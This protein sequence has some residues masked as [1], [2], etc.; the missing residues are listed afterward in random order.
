[1][2]SK[3][4]NRTLSVNGVSSVRSRGHRGSDVK[5]KFIFITGGVM[6][7]LGK[8]IITS[9]T[10][11]L[12]QLAGMKVSCV[13][14]DPYVN[15]DAG[16]MNPIAHGEVFVTDDGGEC[17]MD[18][19]NYERFLGLSLTKEHSL[20]TGRVYSGVIHA[21]REGKYLGQCVQIIPHVTDA[22][23]SQLRK[24][25]EDEELDI[26]VVECGGTVGDIESLP[27][28][29]ALRQM[30]LEDGKSNTLFIHVTLAPVLDVV[31]EQ[32]TKPTQHSVQELRRIGIQ[33]DM[34]AI[35]CR[36]P[37]TAEA[38][39]KIS[40]FGS[41]DQDSVISC[42][43]APSIYKVPEV[44]AGQGMLKVISKKLM[45]PNLYPKWGDWKSI[46]KS[47]YKSKG[48]VRI[49]VVGKYASLPDSYVS[50]YHALSHAAANTGK[51]IEIEWIESEKF[52]FDQSDLT[53]CDSSV[54]DRTYAEKIVAGS[55][56]VAYLERFHGILIP[57]GF[58]KRG[59]EGII[60][61]AN[62]ARL[63]NIPYLGICFGFQLAIVAFAR[64]ACG[65]ESAN[66]TELDPT[67]N[68]PLIE[69]MPEQRTTHDVGGSM[70]LGKH[71]I[72]ILPNTRAARIY[73]SNTIHRRHRHRYEFNRDYVNLLEKQGAVF[74]GHSDNG[75]RTEIF[76]IPDH[77]F[78]YAVQY[79]SEFH[80]RPGNP[81]G[82]FDA[83]VRTAG[84]IATAKDS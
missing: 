7:G 24:I 23:K 48:S 21:E 51:R 30:E 83:F 59:S 60:S 2:Q 20:T 54:K 65:L 62:Y 42:H 37:L 56:N 53:V 46:A 4:T 74:S 69:F 3:R 35:R 57:G 67:T 43:D 49:A 38:R 82:A 8:G 18:V 31:G 25:A 58:G 6:S 76:E 22:I 33:P 55:K 73:R 84:T 36:T 78:Y 41:T 11:K 52:E 17:D 10:A 28:L 14:I 71:K 50:V 63:R 1:M 15:F 70:R 16:T 5:R 32:K 27:F 39:R 75:L 64:Y 47:F 34:L 80:S 19:G 26:T 61:A 68:D 40:L 45:L 72:T 44:L 79:H 77:K 9:S 66:S 29:E 13:K 12:L 81:E